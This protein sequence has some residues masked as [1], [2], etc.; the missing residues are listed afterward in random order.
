MRKYIL[1]LMASLMLLVLGFRPT[2]THLVKG[3]V[4]DES[5]NTLSHVAITEKGRR[6][7]T[8]SGSDGSYSITVSDKNATLVFSYLGHATQE[9]EVKGLAVIDVVLK[10]AQ[11]SLQEVVV[12]GYDRALQGQVAG[13]VISG[14]NSNKMM[15]VRGAPAVNGNFSNNTF[16]TEEYDG[17]TE[18]SFHRTTDDPL[19]TFSIDVD[20]ASYSNVRRFLNSNQ[21]PP[22]GAVR[23]EEMINY[24]TY[25]YPQ[26]TGKDPFSI[27]T[28]ISDCPWNQRHKLVL[29]GLAGKKNSD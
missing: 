3:T 18:N 17:I 12:T 5:G 1:P 23:I 4:K 9:V 22:A 6:T 24:F 14:N 15:K 29:I 28:E 19:S 8:T 20:A 7:A 21:L 16:N 11:Q 26:P 2:T 13:I 25:D 27:N 10:A